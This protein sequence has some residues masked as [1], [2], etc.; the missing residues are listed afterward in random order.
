M[1]DSE[2]RAELTRRW[3]ALPSGGRLYWRDAHPRWRWTSGEVAR[4]VDPEAPLLFRSQSYAT[5]ASLEKDI[6]QWEREY[7]HVHRR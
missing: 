3:R 2:K 7:A 6:A 5:L 4:I 1:T